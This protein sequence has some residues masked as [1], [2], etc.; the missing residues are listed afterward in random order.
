MRSI[1]LIA[2]KI[3]M[4]LKGDRSSAA[5]VALVGGSLLFLL[6][7]YGAKV[8]DNENLIL[9]GFAILIVCLIF[10]K[11]NLHTANDPDFVRRITDW[12]TWSGWIAA[13]CAALAFYLLASAASA[14]GGVIKLSI[15]FVLL[16]GAIIV[17]ATLFVFGYVK[18]TI[19]PC[20]SCG[21]CWTNKDHLGLCPK[22]GEAEARRRQEAERLAVAAAEA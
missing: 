10:Y 7:G 13:L 9:V 17:M 18:S 1:Y 16:A 19:D 2:N 11:W 22:C 21:A 20:T 14:F 3:L 6:F 12:S 15:V 4:W 8:T 5:W